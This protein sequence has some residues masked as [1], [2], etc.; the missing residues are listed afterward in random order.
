MADIELWAGCECTVNRVGDRFYDQTVLSGHQDRIS[1]LNLFAG[2]GVKALRYPVI[3]ERVA[4]DAPD[5]LDWRWTD[6]RLERLR[7]LGVAPIAG[8]VHHGSGPRYAN[9]AGPGF[10][11]GLAAFARAAA[12]RYPW[13]RDWTPV[14]EPLT[15][16]RFCALYG[17]WHPHLADERAFWTT[18]LNEID[19]VRLAMREIR[20]IRAD[21]RLVQTEDLGRTYSTKTLAYQAEFDNA[22]RWMTWD[23]L[24]GRVVPGHLFWDRLS[25]MGL[26]DRLR[27]IADAPCPPDVLGVN[28]YL[29]S[30]RF[31]D[32]RVEL[33]PEHT[34]GGN[35]LT[36]YADVEAVRVLHPSPGGME[37]V[38][39]EAWAR[40]GKTLAV[41]EA[42]NGCTREEQMR[43][44]RET[45]DTASALRRRGVD[46]EA[47]TAWSLLGAFDWNSL[48]TRWT[49]HY[50]SGVFD[51]RGGEPRPTALAGVLRD[52]AAG[53][54]PEH[55]AAWGEGWWRR[56]VRLEHRPV[57]DVTV[58]P[59]LER[60]SSAA[61]SRRPIL[62]TG[63]T[64]ALGQAFARA[65]ELRGLD[66]VLTGRAQL[67]LDSPET[68]ERALD[69]W[70]PWAVV[71]AA[72]LA[73]VDEAERD[74]TLC[75]AVNRDGAAALSAACRR[76]DLPLLSISSD[77]V[78]DGSLGR[79]LR[80]GDEPNPLNVYGRSKAE[81]ERA[82]LGAGGRD[83]IVRTA[84][85]FA[86]WSAKDFAAG[87]VRRLSEGRW[88]SAVHDVVV[89]PT[90]LPDFVSAAFDLMIDGETGLW[91][92]TNPGAL[93]WYDFATVL[94]DAL[95]LDADLVRP[96][97]AEKANWMAKRPAYA[98]LSSER[99]SVLPPLEDAIARYAAALR[100]GGF[101]EGQ[102]D[103]KFEAAAA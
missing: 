59:R 62:I 25:S 54:A 32:H 1:D 13:V 37:V 31:L 98:P 6:E 84:P 64:G 39:S 49:G 103:R 10:A 80:E 58:G 28:H 94:T 50:E 72:G 38:L 71:N 30:D 45:W 14:N 24:T 12:S 68:V 73:R 66:Y 35:G 22:R 87:V 18:L 41:T 51:L 2:L 47:V 82:F 81:M 15:T 34:R 79:S 95:G 21:A 43:W 88:V 16:A 93:S 65:C 97:P 46:I 9:I 89:S 48:L 53:R 52:L 78:F 100:K 60:V 90:Y 29:T 92:L 7:A 55:P 27:A 69:L 102:P 85:L 11:P 4:P 96:I 101:G 42:H 76:R 3:W 74:P 61:P 83:L 8:L 26:G 75:L 20:K 67:R 70:S 86:P 40:Y 56:D 23:L 99:G 63:A 33:Y 91:H 19:G 77:L 36:A 5:L 44:F 57:W 17:H